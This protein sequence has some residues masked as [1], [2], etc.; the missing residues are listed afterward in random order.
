MDAQGRTLPSLAVHVASWQ[1]PPLRLDLAGHVVRG[2]QRQ[3]VHGHAN[4][5]VG[6]LRRR[7]AAAVGLQA[8]Q[9]RLLSQGQQH[10]QHLVDLACSLDWSCT[11]QRASQCQGCCCTTPAP[12]SQHIAGTELNDDSK[13]LERVRLRDGQVV[14]YMATPHPLGY[15]EP[16]GSPA[17][18]SAVAILAE[19]VL[20]HCKTLQVPVSGADM[21]C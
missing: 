16:A 17:Q 13:L 21:L 7:V 11:C 1:G 18:P 10:P 14:H 2:L 20:P 5:L 19:Q 3:R 12:I 15:V 8:Q 6:Q 9:T 4:M